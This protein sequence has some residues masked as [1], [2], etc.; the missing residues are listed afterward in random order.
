MKKRGIK[1]LVTSIIMALI[2]AVSVSGAVL[3]GYDIISVEAYLNQPDDDLSGDIVIPDTDDTEVEDT[4]IQTDLIFNKA[5]YTKSIDLTPG[6]DFEIDGRTAE[7]IMEDIDT[8]LENAIALGMNTINIKLHDGQKVIYISENLPS[9][10]IYLDGEQFDILGYIIKKADE[11][12]LYTLVDFEMNITNVDGSLSTIDA[13][14]TANIQQIENN[15][16]EL[17][18]AYTPSGIYFSSYEMNDSANSFAE[19]KI[20]GDDS[21]YETWI[22]NNTQTALEVAKSA[23]NSTNMN[24][25]IGI[26]VE[27]V[28]AYSSSVD[29]GLEVEEGTADETYL[30]TFADTL[31]LVNS[32][33]FNFVLINTTGS[34]TDSSQP[35]IETVTWWADNITNTNV[36]VYFNIANEKICTTEE[37]W[38]SPDQLTQI[39]VLMDEVT[40]VS[41]V[42][43]SS[44]TDLLEDRSS[45]T[46]V[47]L[48]YFEGKI[49]DV[50][51]L[52]TSLVLY[53]PTSTEFTTYEDT[54]LFY[55]E[56]DE[57]FDILINGEPVV[58]ND[59]GEF[60]AEIDLEIGLNTITFENKGVQVVY[61][62]TKKV[63]LIQTV[64][65]SG[66]TTA[67]GGSKLTIVVSAH[68][69]ATITVYVGGTAVTMTMDSSYDTDTN[70]I[71]TDY[72]GTYTLPAASSTDQVVG[73]ISVSA[74]WSGMTE[75]A[76]GGTITVLKNAEVIDGQMVT[77][78]T[79]NTMTYP[80]DTLGVYTSP[81]NYVLPAGTIDYIASEALE[82]TYNGSV[83]TY[84]ILKSGIRVQDTYL[85]AVSGTSHTNNSLSLTSVTSD[86][87]YTYVTLN[88]EWKIPYTA[89][90][91]PISY[92][93]ANGDDYWV[94]S[95][96]SS[97]FTVT[98]AFTDTASS[99]ANFSSSSLISSASWSSTYMVNGVSYIDLTFTLTQSG[100]FYGMK[101]YYNSSGQMV[102]RFN[103][104]STTLSGV[105]IML[106]SGHSESEGAI[107]SSIGVTEKTINQQMTDKL[108]TALVAKGATVIIT[109]GSSITAKR[110]EA[111]STQPMIYISIHQNSG[112]STATGPEVY[113][114]N[115]FSQP[116]AT[117]LSNAIYNAY[118]SAGYSTKNRGAKMSNYTVTVDSGYVAV[119]VECGFIS[120]NT[121]GLWLADSTNQQYIVNGI[122]SG[123]ESYLK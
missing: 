122:V 90:Y 93:S 74:S 9:Y 83:R 66:S 118:V 62:I 97:K 119:L 87:S 17:I 96:T 65:P 19:Y 3:I 51:S 79:D 56:A 39:M 1:F 86:S 110:A 16:V 37:G 76:T 20:Y 41:G 80:S 50:S 12:I 57:N 18:Y 98:F 15:V 44:I 88:T 32:D 23:V 84:Y 109:D 77:I 67:M 52:F 116:L 73:T 106:D 14:T 68:K 64:S 28:W 5:S 103:N 107:N 54:M 92:F 55:G 40:R 99:S 85:Q 113:Y 53:T 75:T 10:E 27:P 22:V 24:V 59:Y 70:S 95:F 115:P 4:I 43:F 105:T 104:P 11:Y 7:E 36:S 108:Y 8:Y 21:D 94:S 91:S 63:Q 31:S 58:T 100:D 42:N 114:F 101:V 61:R 35:I 46:E 48:S 49:E 34:T 69:S 26:S 111:Q 123:L 45:S 6:V 102:L 120:N 117:S 78:T 71:Y 47:L 33:M 81:D 121:E 30:T 72:I 38:S 60:F 25:Q 13:F 82:Y 29:G 89:S 2:C 112:S